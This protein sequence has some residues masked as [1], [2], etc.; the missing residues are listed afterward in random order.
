MKTSF[1]AALIAAAVAFPV[2]AQ[3]QSTYVGVSVGQAKQKV[4]VD[5][6]SLKE[7]DTSYKLVAGY[8]FDKNFGI[9]AGYVDLGN[10]EMKRF[11]TVES[12]AKSLY[13]AATATLPVNNEFSVF[14]KAGVAANDVDL[15]VKVG[16]A[17]LSDSASRSS[18]MFGLGASY[19]FTPNLAVVAEYENFGKIAKGESDNLNVKADMW[20]IGLRYKF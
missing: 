13:V 7:S 16:G 2:A 14:A 11:G 8:N 4:E 5:A 19:S 18:A 20:T 15:T 6:G 3:A 1:I 17:T 10:A 9:E 12:K